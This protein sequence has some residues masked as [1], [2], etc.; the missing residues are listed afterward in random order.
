MGDSKKHAAASE[1]THR[2]NA[3]L[4]EIAVSAQK[5]SRKQQALLLRVLEDWKHGQQRKDVRKSVLVPVDYAVDDRAYKGLITNVSAG[6]VSIES[7][8]DVPVG[9]EITLTFSLPE[10]EKPFKTTGKITWK[11]TGRFG[12]EFKLTGYIKDHMKRLIESL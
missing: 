3:M 1:I 2:L 6:G 9:E 5:A 10:R 8:N 11:D 12:V 4:Q 7:P